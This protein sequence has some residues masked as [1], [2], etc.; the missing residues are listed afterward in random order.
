MTKVVPNSKKKTL[1]PI[2]VE[3]V[4]KLSKIHSDEAPAYNTISHKGYIHD[5]VNHSKK[6]YVRGTAYT[7]TIEGFWSQFKRS[8]KGTHVHVSPKHLQ[9]Y[10]VEFEFRYN[11]RFIPWTMFDSLLKAF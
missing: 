5:T 11:R 2:I 3:N 10:L 4:H 7:N 1:Q 8:V 9:T 6:E